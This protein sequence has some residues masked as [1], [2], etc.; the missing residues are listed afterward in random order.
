LIARQGLWDSIFGIW[1][2]GP[3]IWNS[4]FGTRFLELGGLTRDLG[5]DIWDMGFGTRY[6]EL[7]LWDFISGT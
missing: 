6:L 3:D 1:D 7:G 5:L 2:L 4:G